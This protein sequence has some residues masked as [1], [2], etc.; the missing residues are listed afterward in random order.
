MLSR[1]HARLKQKLIEKDNLS[2]KVAENLSKLI[3][4]KKG[5]LNRDGTTRK[6]K[7]NSN[8]LHT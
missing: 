1:I 3:L 7:I 4:V 6:E 2:D 8:T 5:Y